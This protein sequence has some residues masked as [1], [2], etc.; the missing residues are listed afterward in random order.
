MKGI[1]VG[2]LGHINKTEKRKVVTH[3]LLP[4]TTKPHI[5]SRNSYYKNFRKIKSRRKNHLREDGTG[6]K[7]RVGSF[8]SDYS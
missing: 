1:K 7:H 5:W 8:D 6:G 4:R 3:E 2:R